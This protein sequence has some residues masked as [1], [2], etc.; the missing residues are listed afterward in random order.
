[1]KIINEFQGDYRWLSNFWD[2]H[3]IA[4]GELYPSV[5]HA[6]CALKTLDPNER[7]RIR[8]APTPGL[9][10]KLGR[11]V[12]MRSDW[13]DARLI[14]MGGLISQK[15]S[16]RNPILADLLK[17]TFDDVLIEGNTWGDTFWGMCYGK[18]ENHL[19]HIIMN[20]RSELLGAL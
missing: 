1:M 13:F 8:L 12:T 6:Y 3:I 19:G 9:A 2:C 17:G 7:K 4:D 14:V 15:F 5:E 10:K 11:S 20:R 18:G 16:D